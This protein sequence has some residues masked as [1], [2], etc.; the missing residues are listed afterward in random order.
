[1]TR[2]ASRGSACPRPKAVCDVRTAD[3]RPRLRHREPPVGREGPPARRRGG[4]PR[5]RPGRGRGGG[6][7]RPARRRRVRSLRRR[8][9]R[10]GPRGARPPGRPGRRALLRRVRR[11]PTPL[12]GF[13]RE[14]VGP[15]SRRVPRHGRPPPA[16]GEAPADAME[17]P[18]GAAVP[19]RRRGARPPT[20]AGRAALGLLR[21]LL[22]S[23]GGARDR[24]GL[25]LRRSGGGAGH[26][27]T[28]CGAPSSIPR[29]RVRRGSGCWPTSSALA[30]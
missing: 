8:A 28:P 9:A 12:R 5:H 4:A 24:G 3:R 6:R 23:A 30:G 19:Q 25:R 18:D 22:R 2:C 21:A 26:D 13:G 7:A 17:P 15:G 14:P 29:S 11:L 10:A 16:R 20:R 27:E 1:M